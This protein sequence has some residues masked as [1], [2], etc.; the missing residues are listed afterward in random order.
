MKIE[1]WQIQKIKEMREKG[2]SYRDISF[3]LGLSHS[4]IEY[5]CKNMKSIE[6][7]RILENDK[8]DKNNDIQNIKKLPKGFKEIK[9][10]IREKDYIVFLK[11]KEEIQKRIGSI[12]DE[13]VFLKLIEAYREKEKIEE[14]NRKLKSYLKIYENF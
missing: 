1:A 4:F 6:R 13:Y 12:A 14:E 11:I 8:E 9:F 10:E 2:M 5:V 3:E 7:N